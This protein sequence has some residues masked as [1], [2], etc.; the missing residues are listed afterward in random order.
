MHDKK[1]IFIGARKRDVDLDILSFDILL[2][3]LFEMI[4]DPD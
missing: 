4:D 2:L 1:S 3:S